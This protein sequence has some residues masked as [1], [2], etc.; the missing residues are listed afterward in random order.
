MPPPHGDQ[1]PKTAHVTRF[2]W[3]GSNFLSRAAGWRVGTGE[4]GRTNGTKTK[5]ERI[6]VD[7]MREGGFGMWVVL[8]FGLLGLVFAVLFVVK[9]QEK[10]VLFLR[11]LSNA[12]LYSGLLATFTGLGA[13]FHKVPANP[14][15]AQSPDLHLI[16]MIGLGEALAG[17]VLALGFLSVM[18]LLTAFGV[19]RLP[20]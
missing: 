10:R 18:W 12:V 19:R 13:V 9:P 11:H 8:A 20:G 14:E 5:G 1:R 16:V 4:R 7:F 3:R 6:M 15:W 2:S 17:L